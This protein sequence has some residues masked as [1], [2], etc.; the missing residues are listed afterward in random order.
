MEYPLKYQELVNFV[1]FTMMSGLCT[2]GE[3]QVHWH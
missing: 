1:Q 3:R 2:P